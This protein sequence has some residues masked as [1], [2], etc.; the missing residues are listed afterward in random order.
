MPSDPRIIQPLVNASGGP[1]EFPHP[2]L[3]LL[4]EIRNQLDPRN[5][6][7]D[8]LRRFT[9]NLRPGLSGFVRGP[10]PIEG[11]VVSAPSNEEY[12]FR[13][14]PEKLARGALL[15]FFWNEGEQQAFQEIM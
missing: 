4:H 8:A 3:H 1:A 11:D 9:L 6:G 15:E 10:A 2:R 13:R 12:V 5:T 7:V 14:P